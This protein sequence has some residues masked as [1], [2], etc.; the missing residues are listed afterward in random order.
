MV[1]VAG[2]DLRTLGRITQPLAERIAEESDPLMRKYVEPVVG[3]RAARTIGR[4]GEFFTDLVANTEHPELMFLP[5]GGAG[6]KGS[7]LLYKHAGKRLVKGGV[8]AFRSQRK[9]A[10]GFKTAGVLSRAKAAGV[11]FKRGIKESVDKGADTAPVIAGRVV[12]DAF[13]RFSPATRLAAQRFPKAG[14]GATYLKRKGILGTTGK[15]LQ[16]TETQLVGNALLD[17]TNPTEA[18]KF[19]LQ[20]AT[21]RDFYDYGQSYRNVYKDDSSATAPRSEAQPA[22][23]PSV[24]R[25][26]R[27]RVPI[28]RESGVAGRST[29]KPASVIE[30]IS[31]GKKKKE[32][33]ND[34]IRFIY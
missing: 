22:S 3:K 32:S 12:Q 10:A 31:Y 11:G 7:Q 13:K 6:V 20:E 29:V 26:N 17:Y 1:E 19:A 24:T 30:E 14:G 5:V 9:A 33:S 28:T 25:Q 15:V 8:R 18:Q 34:G 4:K 16:T 21:G 27:S 23:K 2:R